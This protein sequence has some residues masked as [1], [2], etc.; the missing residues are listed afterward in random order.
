[1]LGDSLTQTCFEGWGA[2]LAN[3]YQ[4]R[5]DIVNRGMSGYN[6]RW[7]LRYAQDECIF[8][9][10]TNHP[11]DKDVVL[12]TIFF[13]A[14][15][16]ALK[17]LDGK[18]VPVPEYKNHMKA[19]IA[20]T[21]QSYP[22]A[23]ILL[24]APPPVHKGQRLDFQKQRYKDKATGI[25]ERTFEHTQHYANACVEV[26]EEEKIA[27]LDMFDAMVEAGGED[28]GFGKFLSDGLHFSKMGH[29]FVAEQVFQAI[30]IDFPELAVA[31]CPVTGQPNNSGSKCE[32][33]ESSGPYHD[34]INFK[35]WEKA[36]DKRKIDNGSKKRKASS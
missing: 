25:P 30:Q 7:Y 24:I 34:E 31:P 11:V 17:D 35:E 5:A 1:M 13:G 23:K 15:D 10:D 2:A 9:D 29:E 21:Q 8:S 14:N 32:G 3:R 27:C 22:G 6:T 12:V 16:A 33:L 4:R 19:M 20:K 28:E 18:H 36:F 26:G